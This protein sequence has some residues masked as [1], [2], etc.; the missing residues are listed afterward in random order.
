M[1]R[2]VDL[3]PYSFWETRAGSGAPVVLLHGLGGSSDWWRRNFDVIAERHDVA[4]IDLVGF[5]RNRFF[6]RRSA[7]PL[8]FDEIAALLVRWIESSFRQ[9]VHL[10]GNS[11]GGQIAIHVAAARPDL[12][13]SL[14]L[15]DSTGIPFEIAPMRHFENLAMPRGLWSFF[16]ILFRDLFRAGPTATALAFARLLRDDARPLM[17]KLT[18]PVLLLWGEHDPLVP[19]DYARRMQEVMPH[20]K[21]RV[22]DHAGHVPM[23]ENAPTFNRELLAFFDE[24]DTKRPAMAGAF[25]WGIAGWTDG[26]A[27]RAGGTRHD[28]VLV[29]GLGMSSAYFVRFARA[30]FDRGLH[31]IAPDVPGFGES[32]DAP[33]MSPRETAERLARW[34]DAVN[35][36]EAIWIGHSLGG[37]VVDHLA[38]L[39]PDLVRRAIAIGPLWTRRRSVFRLL[40]M[41]VVDAFREPPSL[42]AF[43]TRAY[44]RCG[45]R[46]WFATGRRSADDL[47]H[48]PGERVELLAGERDPIPDRT[49]A[50][51]VPGAH[52][53]HF[54]FPDETA[55]VIVAG[56]RQE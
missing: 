47:R 7:L 16:I 30:L 40:A 24:V 34:A 55:A 39:R 15:V 18:L 36:R 1:V 25:S 43:V 19:L 37:N 6:L 54:S 12:V 4:A 48:E 49:D 51:R 50:R 44:W 2:R 26:I 14:V 31:P 22:V 8:K 10:V 33:A 20:A 21:L 23:W 41:L 11:L 35:I 46:R 29:H 38:S 28:V 27:H 3:P 53:C 42:F 56:I 45:F 5:G 52:A 9:P 32:I 17:E 13:R